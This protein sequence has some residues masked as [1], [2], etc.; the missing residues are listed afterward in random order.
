MRYAPIAVLALA[1]AAPAGA[2]EPPLSLRQALEL[3]RIHSPLLP[4][5]EGRLQV[6]AER[7]AKIARAWLETLR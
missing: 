3:A 6:A 5:A 7:A 1:L 2:Q 4:V